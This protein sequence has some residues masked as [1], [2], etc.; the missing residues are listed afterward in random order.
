MSSKRSR[1]AIEPAAV[2][3]GAECARALSAAFMVLT[4]AVDRGSDACRD[5]VDRIK[6]SGVGDAVAWSSE[7]VIKREQLGYLAG[8]ALDGIRGRIE[9]SREFA[10]APRLTSIADSFEE[11][12]EHERRRLVEWVARGGATSSG[13][14][15][16]V[17]E[18]C[19][20]AASAE[21]YGFSDS[22]S[23]SVLSIVIDQ[24]RDAAMYAEHLPPD[25]VVT[26]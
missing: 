4:H 17:R 19:E 20:Y 6:R 8:R 13:S 1:R 14:T 5:F 16:R 25:C 23:S 3:H 24:L 22:L 15:F 9:M 18:I 26:T 11:V 2:D 21:F 12:M 10:L 7:T